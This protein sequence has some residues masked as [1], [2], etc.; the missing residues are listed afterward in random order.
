MSSSKQCETIG[1]KEPGTQ[2]VQIAPGTQVWLCKLCAYRETK[3]L[4]SPLGDLKHFPG[5]QDDDPPWD[6]LVLAPSGGCE[7]DDT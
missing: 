6:E 1:C 2:N 5:V 3:A 4:G 7:N